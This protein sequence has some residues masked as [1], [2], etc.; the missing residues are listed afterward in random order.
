MLAFAPRFGMAY[1]LTGRQRIVL[2]GGAGLF[3]DRPDGNAI[4]PQVQNPP[5][6]TNVTVRNGQLQTLGTGGLPTD[7]PPALNV[8]EYDSK[9]PSSTQWNARRAD[10]APWAVAV[11]VSRTSAST[12]STRCRASTS[13]PS[14]SAP[15]SCRRTR[16]RRCAPTHVPAPRRCRRIRCG[17]F[18]ATARSRSSGA[19]AGGRTTRSSSRSSAASGTASRSDSTTRSASTISRAPAA[20]LQHN[21]DGS[22]TIR[23]DQAEADELLGTAINTRHI[24]KGELRLGSAGHPERPAGVQGARPLVNDW[25]LSGIWTGTDRQPV[26]GRLQLPE[27]RRQPEPHR[28]AGLWRARPGRRRSGQRLQQRSVPAVQSRGV[29]GPVGR[30]RRAWSRGNDYLR[31]CFLEHA[32]SVDRADDPAAEAHGTF[33]CASTCS[34]RPTPAVITGRA[35]TMNLTNPND[36]VTTT[37]LPFDPV[38]GNPVASR[39]LPRGAGVGVANEY[40]DPRR[41]QVQ[42]RFSF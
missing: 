10:A 32:R 1:D 18:A 27:R 23:D 19:A 5:T 41:V 42:V 4:F 11:D 20:R 17:R 34:T 36:P 33:S 38:T 25:R 16:T 28:V 13:T 24:M 2:R 26:H 22:Y 37:N 39:S 40:Q 9:L 7:G 35:T 31:E 3:F 29:P 12:A 6:Y 30:Q 15:R 14:T 21:A 8:Y